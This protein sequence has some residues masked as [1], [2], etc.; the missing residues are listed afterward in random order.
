MLVPKSTV[1]FRHAT[2]ERGD[3]RDGHSLG[4]TPSDAAMM[5]GNNFTDRLKPPMDTFARSALD[6]PWPADTPGT[7]R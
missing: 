6:S 2:F 7:T 1:T 3:R 5:L 4:R